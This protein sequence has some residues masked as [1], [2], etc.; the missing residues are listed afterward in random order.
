MRAFDPEIIYVA[1]R[2]TGTKTCRQV[3]CSS[4][5]QHAAVDIERDAGAVR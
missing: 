1:A 3:I 4:M 2:S 5:N